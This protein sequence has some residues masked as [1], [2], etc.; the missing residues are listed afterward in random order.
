VIVGLDELKNQKDLARR[1]YQNQTKPI[2]KYSTKKGHSSQ[3][4]ILEKKLFAFIRVWQK[5]GL[6][7]SIC[8][9]YND[10]FSLFLNAKSN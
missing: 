5:Y 4:K 6:E 10:I 9:L 3:L 7:R 8:F 1:Q 2:G